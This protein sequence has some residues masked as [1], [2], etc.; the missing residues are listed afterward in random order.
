MIYCSVLHHKINLVHLQ[1]Q[2]ILNLTLYSPYEISITEYLN[3]GPTVV[4]SSKK[5]MSPEKFWFAKS[6]V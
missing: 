3:F 5:I 1:L 6:Q 2:I 4:Y